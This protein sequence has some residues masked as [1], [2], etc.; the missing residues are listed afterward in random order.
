MKEIEQ[1]Q[2]IKKFIEGINPEYFDSINQLLNQIDIE[3]LNNIEELVFVID[4]I[5]GFVES[6]ALAAPSIKRIVPTQCKILEESKNNKNSKIVLVGDFHPENASE[7]NTFAPHS[8]ENTDEAEIID[9]LKKFEVGSIKIKK[10]ATSFIFVPGVQLLLHNTV[11]L[12]RVK[13]I[14]CLSEFCVKHGAIDAKKFFDQNNRNIDVCVY[15]DAIDTFDAEGHNADEITRT[16][17]EEMKANGIKI[18]RKE[19]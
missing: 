3:A 10:N 17:I 2:T 14:G 7:F 19:R 15:E 16:S 8:I 4:M 13:F 11:K 12:K 18:L 1:L 6:G 9:E 5:K